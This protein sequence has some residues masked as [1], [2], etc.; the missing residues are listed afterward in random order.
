MHSHS[1]KNYLKKI[2][3]KKI[4]T[5]D[6]QLSY[7]KKIFELKQK[8]KSTKNK[9]K[10]KEFEDEVYKNRN[11]L[12][13]SCYLLIVQIAN[14]YKNR[15]LPLFDLI[16]EGNIALLKAV[17]Y[18]D[19]RKK[20]KFSTFAS[21]VIKNEI[22]TAIMHR[23]KITR[24][25]KHYSYS[26]QYFTPI[27]KRSRSGQIP[28][29]FQTIDKQL[30][31]NLSLMHTAIKNLRLRNYRISFGNLEQEYLDDKLLNDNIYQ[32]NPEDI[33]FKKSLQKN[34]EKLK[35]ILT[36]Q[37]LEIITKYYGLGNHKP[38]NFNKM[39]KLIKLSTERLRQIHNRAIEKIKN[40][41]L[42]L[43]LKDFF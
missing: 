15:Y 28:S 25:S 17:D 23:G 34:I 42:N 8:I 14:K 38:E 36:P 11:L 43:Y 26:S 29:P 3:H 30:G 7:A 19:Y 6:E 40:S 33:F 10:I 27:S 24:N 1:E 4:L 9:K 39:R 2:S 16:G 41:E 21:L 35:G 5:K 22:L 12:V 32:N 13:E 37:E 18:F 20:I 31:V